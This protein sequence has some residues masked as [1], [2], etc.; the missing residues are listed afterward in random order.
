MHPFIQLD[1]HIEVITFP[2]VPLLRY[3]DASTR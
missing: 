1:A 3:N 2:R